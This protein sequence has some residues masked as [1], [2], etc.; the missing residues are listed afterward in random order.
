MQAYGKSFSKVYNARWNQFTD[1]VAPRLAAFFAARY[2]EPTSML[3]LCCGTG[4]MV[5]YFAERGYTVTG[6]DLSEDM[7]KHARENNAEFIRSKQ[8]T[9][10]KADASDF[11]LRTKVQIAVSTY[12]AMNHL[13]ENNSMK[14]TLHCVYNALEPGGCFIF[15]LNTEMGL[16]NSWGHISVREME[17]AT[18]IMRGLFDEEQGRSYT[19]ISG[20]LK[21]DQGTWDRFDETIYNKAFNLRDIESILSETGFSKHWFAQL[22]RLETPLAKPEEQPRV[23]V[24]AIK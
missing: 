18:I 24:V 4:R 10:K 23:F 22:E 14:M 19:R 8:V 2:P 5:Q 3:D 11:K 6:I 16:R 17:D 15:D 1:M 9:F 13:P 12:D 20:F 7:L 21:N